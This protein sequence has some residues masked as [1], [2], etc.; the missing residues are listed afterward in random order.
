MTLNAGSH[1]GTSFSKE[2]G[3]NYA[4]FSREEESS[5]ISLNGFQ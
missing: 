1:K 3:P 2:V 4:S 5:C